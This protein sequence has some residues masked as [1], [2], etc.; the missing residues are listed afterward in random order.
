MTARARVAAV[1]AACVL[2][3]VLIVDQTSKALVRDGVAVGSRRDL[4]PGVDL[5]HTRNTGVAFSLLQGGGW[6]LLAV[7]AV[8][9]VVVVGVFLARP[10]RPGV[11]LPTGLLLGGAVGNAID[12]VARGAVT[13]FI[14]LPR[15][16]AFNVAD[17]A[18][19]VGVAALLLVLERSDA[20]R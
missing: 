4:L 20:A 18:I 15:W 11:W 1:R 16:P 8:A 6:I 10:E 12:R 2:A 14:A 7:T 19:T 5:V 17:I 13:D 3:G 9:A